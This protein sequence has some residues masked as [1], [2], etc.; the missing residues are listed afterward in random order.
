MAWSRS[1]SGIFVHVGFGEV[2]HAVG[3]YLLPESTFWV[4][5]DTLAV[6]V[7]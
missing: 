2:I 4:Y 1:R 6:V 3:V 7:V 5:S